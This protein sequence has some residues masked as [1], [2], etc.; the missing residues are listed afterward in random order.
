MLAG[1]TV[2]IAHLANGGIQH[3]KVQAMTASQPDLSVLLPL[4]ARILISFVGKGNFFI[5]YCR[6]RFLIAKTGVIGQSW[7]FCVAE[8]ETIFTGKPSFASPD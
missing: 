6:E 4:S 1:S 8:H 7:R 2:P 5:F 3:R